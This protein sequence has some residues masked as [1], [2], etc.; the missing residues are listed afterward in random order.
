MHNSVYWAEY[1]ARKRWLLVGV[2]G[3]KEL[4]EYSWQIYGLTLYFSDASDG[5]SDENYGFM[6]VFVMFLVLA[7]IKI[8][9]I[10]LVISILCFA[11]C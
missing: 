7:I 11:L 1:R 3:S 4:G 6:F 8:V 10:A 2:I 5:C 9:L